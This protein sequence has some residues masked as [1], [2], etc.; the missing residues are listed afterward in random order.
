[1]DA[2]KPMALHNAIYETPIE[3]RG[4]GVNFTAIRHRFFNGKWH[5]RPE[6]V[7]LRPIQEL[8]IKPT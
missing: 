7:G 1:M 6:T 3:G 5:R 4:Q 2:V 8:K